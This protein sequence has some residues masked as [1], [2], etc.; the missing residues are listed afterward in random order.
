MRTLLL[1]LVAAPLAL[2]Q[3]PDPEMWIEGAVIDAIT[4]APVA[5]A[6]VEFQGI[7]VKADAAGHFRF[8]GLGPG[9]YNLNASAAGYLPGYQAAGLSSEQVSVIVGIPLMPQGV[10]AGTVTDALSGAPVAGVRVVI[11]WW[12]QSSAIAF[13]DVAGHFQLEGLHAGEHTLMTVREGYLRAYRPVVL[14]AGQH[15]GDVRLPLTP[16]AVIAG[17]V[18]DEDGFP[19]RYVSVVAL[20]R[21]P[22]GEV[23]A[24]R[25]GSTDDLG[26]FRVAG[27]SSGSYYL[28]VEP[29]AAK[30]WDARYT[31]S[32]YPA[33]SEFQGAEA[34]DAS[35]GQER[36]GILIRLPKP[37]GVRVEGRVVLPAGFSPGKS[38]GHAAVVL[39]TPRI[40]PCE[41]KD[42]ATLAED[43][44]FVLNG[45]APGKYRLVA[46][47]PPPYSH[48]YRL[49]EEPNLQ[50]GAA[51]LTGIVLPTGE[52]KL[53]DLHADALFEPGIQIDKV[54]VRLRN[55]SVRAEAR[56]APSG[57]DLEGL[58]PG[59]Y[60]LV[61]Y[62]VEG[63]TAP[64]SARLGD[65]KLTS[66]DM[67]IKG[68]N[69]ERLTIN[70]TSAVANVEGV[71]VDGSGQPVR[72]KYA[73]FRS[74]KP[75]LQ[76]A[77]M[78]IVKPG[79]HFTAV[80]LP[81]EYRVWTAANVPANFWE[82][83]ADA[84]SG[85][86]RLITVVEGNNP[87]LRLLHPAIQ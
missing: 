34:I 25:I 68:P 9:S 40:E 52:F 41:V 61:V 18:E 29:G 30:N 39:L 14:T 85:Q 70:M 84:P 33:A 67:E 23:V 42:Y 32:F 44:S 66:A 48:G 43:G 78:G 64:V 15:A 27:L 46:Q 16:Q 50:V 19:V 20:T 58:P 77:V 81:G 60:R 79:G 17:S 63:R 74:I 49:P 35:A 56:R 51:G 6:R 55:R 80:L 5:G 62:S 83:T 37:A 69:Q 7:H 11:D 2:A 22:A 65:A 1:A 45:V 24:S 57:Y 75:A 76:P 36:S 4:G 10:I 72:G 54:V 71:V 87:P 21:D 13:S 12:Q 26:K 3:V 28:H 82:G 8:D 73:L 31:G 59:T 86:G 53:V 47:L 38:G